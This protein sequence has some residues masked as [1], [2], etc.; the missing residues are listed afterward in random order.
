MNDVGG[1]TFPDFDVNEKLSRINFIKSH[2]V[3]VVRDIVDWSDVEIETGQYDFDGPSVQH[4]DELTNC[5]ISVILNVWVS[6][7]LYDGGYTV[8]SQDGCAGLASWVAAMVNRFPCITTIEVG[9]RPN[10]D[11]YY[12]ASTGLAERAAT[13]V[14]QAQ[15]IRSALP[16][17]TILLGGLEATAGGFVEMMA[18]AFPIVDGLSIIPRLTDPQRFVDEVNVLRAQTNFQGPI[19]ITAVDMDDDTTGIMRNWI[20]AAAAAGIHTFIPSQWYGAGDGPLPSDYGPGNWSHASA[21]IFE[22]DWA[23]AEV[24]QIEPGIYQL[25]DD[26]EIE[27]HPNRDVWFAST[28]DLLSDRYSITMD[29]VPFQLFA[30]QEIDGVPLSAHLRLHTDQPLPFLSDEKLHGVND[31][32]RAEM[33]IPLG[34]NELASVELN[35]GRDEALY[36]VEGDVLILD[37]GSRYRDEFHLIVRVQEETPFEGGV[38]HASG[39]FGE[40]IITLGRGRH[41]VI[42]DRPDVSMVIKRGLADKI[43]VVIDEKAKGRKVEGLGPNDFVVCKFSVTPRVVGYGSIIKTQNG[44]IVFTD[45]D[46]TPILQTPSA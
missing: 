3:S 44:E 32:N 39:M 23:N 18:D 37:I 29:G 2:G 28:R 22:R 14:R 43:T 4:F 40:N 16:N 11:C 20:A 21:E 26:T 30:G 1:Q 41:S 12:P 38:V 13:V 9:D 19:W 33:R 31:T 8:A 7:P 10:G 5:G 46:I 45:Y 35:Y 34:G 17:I 25:D 36:R 27:T 24:A 6:N 15:A 42:M